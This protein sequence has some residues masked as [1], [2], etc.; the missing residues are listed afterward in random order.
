MAI[1]AAKAVL[2]KGKTVLFMCDF[3]ERFAKAMFEFDK[4]IENSVKLVNSMKLLKVPMIVTEQN[5]KAL[6]KTVPQLDISSAKG[7]FEK[8]QFSMCTDEVNEALS[9]ICCGTYPES[10]ILIGLETHVC[11][12][13]TAIDLKMSGYEVHVVADCCMSR[14]QEDRLLA[15]QRMQAMGCHISTSETVIFKLLGDAKHEEF[16][17]IQKLVKTPT[18]Y[19][20]LVPVSKI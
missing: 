13:N 19:T 9:S 12:E 15:L 14:T 2:K 20:G 10:V 5:P 8:T 18:L 3:Q 17:N 1:N 6:G 4:V 16:K 7:P 11:V